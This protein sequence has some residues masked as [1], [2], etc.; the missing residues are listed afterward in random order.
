MFLGIGQTNQESILRF[1]HI[2]IHLSESV[3]F[4]GSLVFVYHLLS[5]KSCPPIRINYSDCSIEVTAR[6]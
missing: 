6:L 2:C 4:S 1:S 5:G 3:F